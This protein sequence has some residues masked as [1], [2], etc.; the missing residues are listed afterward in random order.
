MHKTIFMKNSFIFLLILISTSL[1]SQISYNNY[2]PDF[3]LCVT[4]NESKFYDLYIEDLS[5]EKLMSIKIYDTFMWPPTQ[6]IYIT[7]ANNFYIG[8]TS[9]TNPKNF[10]FGENIDDQINWVSHTYM[11]L[12]YNGRNKDEKWHNTNSGFIAFA[13]AR[14]NDTV[15]GWI[16]LNTFSS[17][18][19]TCFKLHDFAY[20]QNPEEGIYVGEGMPQIAENIV[21]TDV[22]DYSDGRD[23]RL[24][25]YSPINK[26]GISEYRVFIVPGQEHET[27]NLEQAEQIE[28]DRYIALSNDI[29]DYSE[30]FDENTVDIYGDLITELSPYTVYIMTVGDM[31]E[32]D[33]NILSY[34][35]NTLVLTTTVKPVHN[36]SVNSFYA[37]GN[38][39]EIN[40]EFDLPFNTEGI[41][42]YRL[43][44]IKSQDLNSFDTVVAN[45]VD[46][47][48]YTV[49][50]PENSSY[51]GNFAHNSLHDING[52]GLLPELL[53]QTCIV[54]VADMQYANNNAI[55]VTDTG[56]Y[57]SRPVLAISSVFAFDD[58]NEGNASDIR[59]E[60][61][62][63][64][65]ESDID[66]YRIFVVKEEDSQNFS[67]LIANSISDENRFHIIFPDDEFVSTILPSNLKTVNGES[68][69]ND[70][71]YRVF[72]Q[73]RADLIN[74]DI[75][76][77]SPKSRKI[78]I[79]NPN[80]FKTGQKEGF[81]VSH[82]DFEP[83]TTIF[84][85]PSEYFI[86]KFF[87]FDF[88]ADENIDA[89]IRLYRIPEAHG[90]SFYIDVICHGNTLVQV[91]ENNNQN[92][93]AVP[94]K[95]MISTMNSFKDSTKRIVHEKGGWIG[96]GI[97]GMWYN[98]QDKYL[99]FITESSGIQY[100]A[101]VS[102]SIYLSQ[103][104]TIKEYA[105]KKII[106]HIE[107]E[108]DGFIQIFPNPT[109]GIINIIS[110][111]GADEIKISIYDIQG[112]SFFDSIIKSIDTIDISFLK[113]GVYILVLESDTGIR[114]KKIVVY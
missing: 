6:S 25:F 72:A 49:L 38:D 81:M 12:Y 19:Q 7:C 30:N 18:D 71:E 62:A 8:V 107:S 52:D 92:A 96:S 53:Y 106:S 42:E 14:E 85:M 50:N 101:W 9:G 29:E 33:Y 103:H 44:F 22:S 77:L 105:V 20:Q 79:S 56:F 61:T 114:N 80:M 73:T 2:T 108:K 58:G 68:I 46:P 111:E 26:T 64:E 65:D 74:T 78:V 76:A 82:F 112:R 1:S 83:D 75:N 88:T 17:E 40:V 27:F 32:L 21:I 11:V 31:I 93:D 113:S 60:F 95:Y 109:N 104:V 4:R 35:S 59:V 15:Y 36:L 51:I 23:M 91:S 5:E 102:L 84:T 98:A 67:N 43:M 45:N 3:E 41:A 37:G 66:S 100:K 97:W 69:E 39:Y 34:P 55:A 110:S 13:V 47:L 87:D 24:S 54:S 28:S 16:R 94:E 90:E 86:E 10:D 99:C 63:L 89:S 57:V 48:F 70:T